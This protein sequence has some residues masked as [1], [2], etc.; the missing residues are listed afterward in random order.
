M[1]TIVNYSFRYVLY[2]CLCYCWTP[3]NASRRIFFEQLVILLDRL[4]SFGGNHIWNKMNGE[5]THLRASLGA[6]STCIYVPHSHNARIVA[7]LCFS[8]DNFYHYVVSSKF[9]C[10]AS[11]KYFENL[12]HLIPQR[13]ISHC[14]ELCTIDRLF[15]YV[16]YKERRVQRSNLNLFTF[17]ISKTI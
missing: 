5:G 14:T 1:T 2:F 3:R 11:L 7:L 10:R 16:V 13:Q 17:S 12:E 6:G 4:G 15:Q 9:R 8:D